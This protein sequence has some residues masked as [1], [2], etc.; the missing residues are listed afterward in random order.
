[1]APSRLYCGHGPVVGAL[2]D[3][4][5]SPAS[6]DAVDKIDEYMRHRMEREATI[7]AILEV[8]IND[9]R[10]SPRHSIDAVDTRMCLL[11]SVL[12]VVSSGACVGQNYHREDL[13]H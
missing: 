4:E 7:L 13:P 3:S 11:L 8:C 12:T 6:T 5:D 9:V 10:Q 1:V 2:N